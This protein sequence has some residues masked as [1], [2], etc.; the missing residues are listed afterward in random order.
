ME[1]LRAAMAP[2]RWEGPPD[3]RTVLV[4]WG[5][6]REAIREALELL[7]KES[8]RV[9]MLHFTELWPP[10]AYDFPEGARLIAVESNAAGQLETLL[11]S[12]YGV[13]CAGSIRRFDGQPLDAVTIVERF[14]E[15][16]K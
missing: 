11:A 8:V 5:S 15:L 14:R 13:R 3:A 10:P 16:G 7:G 1:A 2:P 4:G 6:S 12:A 9:A